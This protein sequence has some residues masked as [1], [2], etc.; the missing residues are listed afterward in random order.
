[1]PGTSQPGVCVRMYWRVGL[2]TSIV[3]GPTP[4]MFGSA[5]NGDFAAGV[6]AAF[7]SAIAKRNLRVGLGELDGDLA[8]RVVGRDARDVGVSFLCAFAYSGTPSIDEV[9]E[10][11]GPPR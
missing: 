8:G 6:G 5:L 4:G 9:N 7:A 11:N 10:E 2:T 3:Y 1:M